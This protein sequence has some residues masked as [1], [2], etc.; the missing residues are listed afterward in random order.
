MSLKDNEKTTTLCY[1]LEGL[2]T[3]HFHQE[4]IWSKLFLI[5][6]CIVRTCYFHDNDVYM[7]KM[8]L[9]YKY[10]KMFTLNLTRLMSPI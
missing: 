6:K 9:L 3:I 8:F 5:N 10:D 1:F 2:K 7:C 4:V